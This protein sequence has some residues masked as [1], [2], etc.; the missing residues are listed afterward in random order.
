MRLNGMLS[1]PTIDASLSFGQAASIS[2]A[3]T[4][5]KDANAQPVQ[6]TN[7]IKFEQ[8]INAP[9]ALSTNDIYRNTKTQLSLA[10]EELGI[11]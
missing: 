6:T 4:T 11:K 3:A 1:T 9:T 8:I 2:M 7:E 5:A 10:K